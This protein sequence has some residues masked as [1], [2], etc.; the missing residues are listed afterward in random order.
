LLGLNYLVRWGD[1]E[2]RKK[3]DI[4]HFCLLASPF[5]YGCSRCGAEITRIYSVDTYGP[6]LLS[7]AFHLFLLAF[8][9]EP[10]GG[11][12]KKTKQSA[13]GFFCLFRACLA[14][15]GFMPGIR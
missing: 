6:Y 14:S 8:V 11:T 15:G 2:T 10:T 4:D 1:Y 7:A 5:A 9:A 3:S 13:A 12:E